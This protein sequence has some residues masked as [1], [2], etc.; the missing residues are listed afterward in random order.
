M[1]VVFNEYDGSF[2]L[3]RIYNLKELYNILCSL[4]EYRGWLHISTT[5]LLDE[6]ERSSSSK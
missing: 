1:I 4:I 2:Y 5:Q 6:E 3:I